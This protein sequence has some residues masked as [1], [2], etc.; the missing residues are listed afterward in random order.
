MTGII[1]G[2]TSTFFLTQLSVGSIILTVF[3]LSAAVFFLRPGNKTPATSHLGLAFLFFAV[4]HFAYFFAFSFYHPFTAFHRWL[5]VTFVLL[6]EI[7]MTRYILCF[8]D[9][10]NS[11]LANIVLLIQYIISIPIILFF[12]MSTYSAYPVFRF[13][14]HYWDFNAGFSSS[15][16]GLLIV[17]NNITYI[18]FFAF[19]LIQLKKK[20][21][22]WM[23][24]TG[25]VFIIGSIIPAFLNTMNLHGYIMRESFQTITNMSHLFMFTLLALA[26]LSMTKDRFTFM[27]KIA[28]ITTVTFF[29]IFIVN[30]HFT[31]IEMENTFTKLKYYDLKI[32]LH[33]ETNKG[34]LM[35]LNCYSFRTNNFL[36]CDSI[37][38]NRDKS[39]SPDFY[40]RSEY[41][42]TA[43]YEKIKNLPDNNFDENLNSIM[44]KGDE[45]FSCYKRFILSVNKSL[46]ENIKNRGGIICR[47]IDSIQGYLQYNYN[48]IR[49]LPE[50]GFRRALLLHLKKTSP[51]FSDFSSTI[52]S[53][54]ET[55][56]VTDNESL[57]HNVLHFIEN[58]QPSGS[59]RFR[60]IQNET[61]LVSSFFYDAQ[62]G[63]VYEGMF[64]YLS[65][66]EF[67]HGPALRM[68]LLMIG[69]ML[70][71][72]LVYPFFF[73]WSVYIPL[74]AL[75]GGVKKV[76]DDD[77][78]FTAPV[79]S[80][81]EIGF[82]TGSF[83]NMVTRLKENRDTISRSETR[84]RELNDLLPD[85]IYET[86]MNLNIIYMNKAGFNR[87]GYTDDD[88][89]NGLSFR[90]LLNKDE[91]NLLE[92]FINNNSVQCTGI[93]S[94]THDLLTKN[95]NIF[96]G[97]TRAVFICNNTIPSGLRGIIRDVT[98]K[99]RTEDA[100]LQLQKMETIGTL[101]AGLTHDFNNILGG[102]TGPLSLLMFSI[103]K[104]GAVSSEKLDMHLNTMNESVKRATELVQQLVFLSRKED[105]NLTPVD[106]KSSIE[107]ITRIC[108]SAFD[109]NIEIIKHIPDEEI[110]VRAD[111]TQIE[112][113]LLNICINASHAMTIMRGSDEQYGGKL[114][115]SLD[116]INADEHF[117]VTH[118]DAADEL[119]WKISITDTGVGMDSNT[120]SKIFIPFYTTKERG[121]GTGL[122]LAM[123]YNIVRHHRGFIDVYSEPGSGTTFNIYLPIQSGGNRMSSAGVETFIPRGEGKILIADDEESI[124]LTSRLMLERCGYTVLSACDGAEALKIYSENSDEIKAVVLD[125]VMPKMSG[126][127]VYR[128]LI[129]INPDVKVLLASGMLNDDRIERLSI[130]RGCLF[131]QKPYTFE[132]LAVAIFK[133]LNNIC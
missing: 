11:K 92:Q 97:E 46:P 78:D 84:F 16:V 119:Y 110:T 131:I 104:K 128:K 60:E 85:I 121:T 68:I 63:L 41:F 93:F 105:T 57:R 35:F 120:I 42:N 130:S 116:R 125:F 103:Q 2:L 77:L 12:F 24:F 70:F 86:D 118:P 89:S 38:K 48:H 114:I 113:M 108:S 82:I 1:S 55:S 25:A 61:H 47:R 13:D 40:S 95:G 50:N 64:S 21:F 34:N 14:G 10:R 72:V 69:V 9:D 132:N 107:H 101:I 88:I 76:I 39:L 67:M 29:T 75:L 52:I 109:K 129:K 87:T 53:Y 27:G 56:P 58:M 22:N 17:L 49:H 36:N 83:N 59:Q 73:L 30:A 62:S 71:I 3:G 126:E 94:R 81:D 43:V 44:S 32:G 123:A 37:F 91:I 96:K 18:I 98:D 112:Q 90:Q 115:I 102:I 19:R 99:L 23:L 100:L 5:T 66:R 54:I 133:L 20:E 28:G 51:D 127:Q 80:E 122:G 45:Y 117:R 79:Y 31:F 33:D 7:H 4:F 6:N 26:H 106:I 74:N 8:P 124:L 15:L 65:Y 111:P